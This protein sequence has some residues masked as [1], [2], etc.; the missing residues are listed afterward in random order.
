MKEA[1]TTEQINSIHQKVLIKKKVAKF[2]KRSKVPVNAYY[3]AMLGK[4]VKSKHIESI[5]KTLEKYA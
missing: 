4:E 5:L 1:L 3:H 2:I